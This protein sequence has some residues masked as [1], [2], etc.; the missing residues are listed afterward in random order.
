MA[1]VEED[2]RIA[3]SPVARDD[4]HQSINGEGT[5]TPPGS[6]PRPAK[7]KREPNPNAEALKDVA[8]FQLADDPPPTGMWQKGKQPERW[9][10]TKPRRVDDL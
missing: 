9:Y 1:E 5:T 7:R 8:R 10:Y 2:E 4:Q 3:D 6:P